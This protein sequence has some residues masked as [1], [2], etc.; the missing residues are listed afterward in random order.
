M[1]SKIN[2][3]GKFFN[4]VGQ[5]NVFRESPIKQ[6]FNFEVSYAGTIAAGVSNQAIT[7]FSNLIFPFPVG[8]VSVNMFGYYIDS[9]TQLL[10]ATQPLVYQSFSVTGSSVNQSPPS[11]TLGPQSNLTSQFFFSGVLGSYINYKT[12][13]PLYISPQSPMTF[14]GQAYFG[15]LSGAADALSV[16]CRFLFV[17][18]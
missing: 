5:G 2:F 10:K 1:G 17:K 8:L 13:Q 16:V 18:Y 11:L 15:A 6:Y 9:A 12:E 14:T 4:A 3:G 7:F